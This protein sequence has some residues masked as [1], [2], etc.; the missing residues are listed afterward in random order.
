MYMHGTIDAVFGD[1]RLVPSGNQFLLE[2][3][4]TDGLRPIGWGAI[5]HKD[6]YGVHS[7][8]CH[9]LGYEEKPDFF[10]V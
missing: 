8:A 9:Q 7:V 3:Y 2:V 1:I 10:S 4:F 6:S 5:C